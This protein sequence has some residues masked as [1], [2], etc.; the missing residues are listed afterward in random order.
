MLFFYP[1]DFTFVCPT[2]ICDFSD[3]AEEFRKIGCEVVAA[4]IDSKFSHLAWMLTPR[5]KGGLGKMN[6]PIIA[7]LTKSIGRDY[8]V[9]LE[10]AGHTAR[11]TFIIDGKGILRHM[12]VND[13]PAGRNVDEYLRLVQAYQYVD[14]H[15]EVQYALRDDVG[16]SLTDAQAHFP[17]AAHVDR[18]LTFS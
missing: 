15:G 8:G 17:I 4:S 1:L 9:M 5:N 6:I 12:S 2:E 14:K 11:G 13:P 18:S 16:N 10:E 3:R 7:D